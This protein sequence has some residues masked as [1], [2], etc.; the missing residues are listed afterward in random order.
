MPANSLRSEADAAAFTASP[1]LTKT[2]QQIVVDIVKLRFKG[3]TEKHAWMV[4]AK[5]RSR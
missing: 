3:K 4:S 1:Q 5:N 2:L